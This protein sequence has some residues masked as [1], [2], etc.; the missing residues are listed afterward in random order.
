MQAL[1]S[2]IKPY[3]HRLKNQL[4][5]LMGTTFLEVIRVVL[6][7]SHDLVIKIAE[8]PNYLKRLFGSDDMHLL[9]KC[10]CPIWL[11]KS[12]EKSGTQLTYFQVQASRFLTAINICTIFST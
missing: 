7:N 1:K 4:D 5:I 12:S 10:P 9:R 2:L 11:M 8:N 6:R 3:Q